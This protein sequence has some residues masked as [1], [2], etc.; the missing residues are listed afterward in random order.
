MPPRSAASTQLHTAAAI[1]GFAAN[2]LFCR[3]ALGVR[4]IDA[5]SFTAL[6]VVSGAM[7]LAL[8][9]RGRARQAGDAPARGA[10]ALYAYA[11]CFSLAYLR[12]P[13]GLGALLLFGSVQATMIG[14]GIVS[15]ERP[16]RAEWLGLA[17]AVAG[18]V[19]LFRRG[20]GAPDPAGAA[21]MIVAGVAWGRYSLVGRG[22]AAPLV[23]TARNF[24]R[25]TPLALGTLAVAALAGA[26]L[27]SLAVH[28]TSRGVAFAVA[29]GAIASGLGYALWYAAL[30]SLTA[31]Q[32]AVVQLAA[33][34]LAA[35]A[36]VVLLSETPTLRLVVGGAAIACGVTLAVTGRRA[37]LAA[38]R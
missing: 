35:A 10:L 18:V 29:S 12:L 30:P 13:A 32:A 14:A 26:R 34:L 21:L 4:S 38:A 8:L 9:A 24:V 5:I 7:V 15:G 22:V 27:P 1:V 28:I 23:A 17:L 37:R 2:S 11:I 33:P 16:T 36:G 6:R 20:L 31:L 19:A 25:A 3:A